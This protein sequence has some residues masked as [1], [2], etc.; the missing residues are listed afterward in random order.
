[1]VLPFESSWSQALGVLAVPYNLPTAASLLHA[2]ADEILYV[3]GD[4]STD[5]SWYTKRA[6]LSALYAS[7]ELHMLSDQSPGK[8]DT[9]VFLENRLDDYAKAIQ[10][11]SQVTKFF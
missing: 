11:C 8:A 9:W 1:M 2:T 5:F 7:S 6:L 3:C 10:T 4:E